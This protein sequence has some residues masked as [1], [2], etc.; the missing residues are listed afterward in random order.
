MARIP[1]RQ[2]RTPD[3]WPGFVDALA[4]LLVVIIFLVMIFTVA[5]F[6]ATFL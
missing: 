5:Q 4:A 3:I 6:S 1:E 2:R